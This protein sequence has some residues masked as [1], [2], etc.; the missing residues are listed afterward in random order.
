MLPDTFMDTGELA[1]FLAGSLGTALAYPS[2][3]IEHVLLRSPSP[4]RGR[5]DFHGP[6]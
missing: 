4:A 3:G 2:V 1:G 5:K 6:R